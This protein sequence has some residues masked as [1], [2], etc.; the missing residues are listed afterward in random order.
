MTQQL[1]RANG[2]L[3][4][5]AVQKMIVTFVALG[6][7]GS[8]VLID[9]ALMFKR[10]NLIE[11]EK[12]ARENVERHVLGYPWVGKPKVLG[13]RQAL[14]DKGVDPK[15]IR[16][17]EK[18]VEDVFDH[19]GDTNL[20]IV[21]I[22]V[23]TAR[24]A[25][26]DWAVK[27]NIPAIYGGF[28]PNGTGGDVIV[29]PNP[30]NECLRCADHHQG[31]DTYKG[32]PAS[33]HDSSN[34]NLIMGLKAVPALRAPI[35]AIA[36]DMAQIALSMI[37]EKGGEKPHILIHAMNSWETVFSLRD[38]P[39][40]SAL[41]LYISKQSLLGLL[42]TMRLIPAKTKGMWDLQIKREMKSCAF[43]RWDKCPNHSAGFSA[44]EI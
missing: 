16:T 18:K 39:L 13:M 10:F 36:S 28:Y 20:L 6:S 8:G 44:D 11:P 4:I 14:I 5:K 19:I 40:M 15:S 12:L 27:H 25:V 17:Y 33:Y 24:M 41:A 29:V 35:S 31:L 7:L 37:N 34:L 21:S 30:K 43:K 2:I 9:L 22:D 32:A 23:P 3:D 1:F 26:N 38:S 42:P